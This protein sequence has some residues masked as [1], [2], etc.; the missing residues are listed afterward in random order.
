MKLS[1]KE[2]EHS[3]A[4]KGKSEPVFPCRQHDDLNRKF[5]GTSKENTT[6]ADK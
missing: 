4:Y 3:E 6:R 5:D 1:D 2:N